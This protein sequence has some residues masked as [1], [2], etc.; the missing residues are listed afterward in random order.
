M[1]FSSFTLQHILFMKFTFAFFVFLYSSLSIAQSF[2]GDFKELVSEN[3]NI[4]T[5]K[6][7]EA[8]V[9]IELCTATMIRVRTSWNGEFEAN[10]PWMVTNYSWSKVPYTIEN[11]AN[12]LLVTTD[13]ISLKVLKSPFTIAFYDL[14]GN[15]LTSDSENGYSINNK[16][17]SSSKNLQKDEHFFGFGERMDFLDRRGKE[18]RLDVGRGIGLPHI[19]GAYN[20]LE[21]NYCPVPFFMSTKGYG[22]FLHNSHPSNWDMGYSSNKTYTFSAEGGEMDYYFMY[23]PNFTSILDSY[24]SLT[25]KSPLLPKF[26]LGLQVGT[27]SGGTWGHEEKT[28]TDYVVD[29]AKKFRALNIP[30]DVLHLDSTWRIFGENGGK[31]ATS[32]EWRETFVNPEKMFKDLYDLNLNMVGVHLRPRFDNGKN[33]RLLDE[34]RAKGYVYPEDDN[35]GEFV[36]FFDEEAVN[37]WFDNGVKRVADQGAMFLKTDEGSAFGR[38][39]NE[40]NKTGPQGENIKSLHNIFPLAYAKAA[41]KQFEDYNKLRGMNNTREGFAGIQRYPFIFAGDWPSEWQ[42]FEPVIK[43]GLNIGLSGVGNWAHC[44][45][46]FEHVADPELYIRWTQFGLLSP[47]AHLF[48]MEHPNYKEPWNYGDEALRIFK[49]YDEM[50]YELIPYLYSNSYENHTKGTPQMRALVLDFQDDENVYDITDQYMLGES[51]MICP[52]TEKGAKTRVVYLPEGTWTNYWTGEIYQGKKYYSVLCPIDQLPIF[53]REGA[54]IPK[55][56]LVQY[57]GEK[58]FSKLTIEVWPNASN[59]FT[60]YNDDGRTLSYQNGNFNTTEL[61]LNV[62]DSHI[63]FRIAATNGKYK[64]GDISYD[65]KL[66]M[67]N[68]PAS[69]S[70]NN[71]N[72]DFDYIDSVLTISPQ[73]KSNEEIKILIK[74]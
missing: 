25:G 47:I 27:Y 16:K 2:T 17:V 31:G 48:G 23:G 9:K 13:K 67:L 42:Y 24:T 1:I 6:T 30:L 64:T 14:E 32:F 72:I 18:V 20:V 61:N 34:A 36:N 43:A 44:M 59:T 45:G 51:L 15:L 54:I 5:L 22:I 39:A 60:I 37:W 8:T 26:A 28:S 65:I 58:E 41:Y 53:I 73:L 35:P 71:E 29:L 19:V 52:V 50:R 38:K 55:Q 3:E 12:D 46:G 7:E 10:E 57:I 49:Q 68:K 4:I 11:N 21:A 56:E 70:V 40:S 66:H 74:K 69:V 63:T 33:L 62:S